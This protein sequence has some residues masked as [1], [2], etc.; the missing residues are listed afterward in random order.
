MISRNI[1]NT[2]P[3]L[4]TSMNS[5]FSDKG[6]EI[7]LLKWADEKQQ[8]TKLIN[9][10]LPVECAND[11]YLRYV[12]KWNSNAYNGRYSAL[13][14][15]RG[16]IA[17]LSS[18]L[19]FFPVSLNK[20]KTIKLR[21]AQAK[22]CADACQAILIDCTSPINIGLFPT[23]KKMLE[24]A[25]FWHFTPTPPTARLIQ[26]ENESKGEYKLRKNEL[27]AM[28][29]IERLRTDKWW[30]AK[31]ERAYMQFCEHCRIISGK[32]RL[33]VSKYVSETGRKEFVSRKKAGDLYIEK[34]VARNTETG[35]EIPMRGVVDGSIANKELRRTE[36]M[37]RMRGFEDTADEHKLMGGFF[38]ITAPSKYHAFTAVERKDKWSS[39]NNK[40]YQGYNPSQTQNYLCAT[41]QKARA[42]L[43]RLEIP[44]MGF[45]VAEPHHDGTP[46]WHALFFF[47]PEHEG[48]I[49]DV[50]QEY[51]LAEDREELGEDITPRFDYKRID[52]KRGT[53]TGYIAK[54]IAKNIDG[55][56]LDDSAKGE[57]L[58][59]CAWASL[60][61][62]RQFQQIGG[63]PV[64]VWREL[65]RLPSTNI[66][67]ETENEE[68]PAQI[69]SFIDLKNEKHPLELARYSADIGNWSMYLL[70][71]GGIF[72]PRSLMPVSL[73]Y[74]QVEN[75]YG[76]LVNKTQGV[77][78][79]GLEKVT[80]EGSWEIV[81]ATKTQ[82][83][84]AVRKRQFSPWSSVNNCTHSDKSKL[85]PK[86]KNKQ[87]GVVGSEKSKYRE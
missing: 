10:L 62:I 73:T 1:F 85:N 65:R 82:E 21:K 24:Y 46:H 44:L 3:K 39:V 32:T 14:W 6:R 17:K 70:S 52:K 34:M 16:E 41:W 64:G 55:Y 58:S 19:Q 67:T 66:K 13:Q 28:G 31:I 25:N 7:L 84:N 68:S 27:L 72:C 33:G 53:A 45:R 29:R 18:A 23:E 57:A 48:E 51:F 56:K 83:S 69:K 75:S 36:L 15:L 63:A 11:V 80:R 20:L 81:R 2:Q 5:R 42:K 9:K 60:W 50:L 26:E 43:N 37:V 87:K 77:E 76:E 47:A 86:Q 54:Y 78:S 35:E 12:K 38:T 79:L 22:L 40:H 61:G 30:E 71:M 49:L 8:A 74:K 59:A 4:L